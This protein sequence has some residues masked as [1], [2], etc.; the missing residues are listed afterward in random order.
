MPKSEIKSGY[1][2]LGSAFFRGFLYVFDK[3]TEN[4]RGHQYLS[5]GL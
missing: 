3:I 5:I 4:F 2:S 1:I